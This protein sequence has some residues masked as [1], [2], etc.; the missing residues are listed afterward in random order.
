MID[1]PH[2]QSRKSLRTHWH[3]AVVITLAASRR[4]AKM[5]QEHLALRLGWQ[6]TRIAR[7]ESGERRI[8]VPEFICI[9][10]GLNIDPNQLLER[11]LLWKS[12]PALHRRDN[13]ETE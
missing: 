2:S 3:S 9:A 5:T 13:H 7:I 10:N 4:E 11:V 8:D 1:S 6:R 12:A